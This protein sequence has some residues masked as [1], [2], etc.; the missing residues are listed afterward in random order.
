MSLS[1]IFSEREFFVFLA[2]SFTLLYLYGRTIRFHT[3]VYLS[4]VCRLKVLLAFLGTILTVAVLTKSIFAGAYTY[5]LVVGFGL[6]AFLDG[7]SGMLRTGCGEKVRRVRKEGLFLGSKTHSEKGGRGMRYI[8][9]SAV[10][11]SPG[12]YEY[13]LISIE[14]AKEW[15]SKGPFI[16][17]IGYQETADVLHKLTGYPIE[18]NRKMIKMEVGDE[19]LV[20]RLTIR[21]DDVR[22]KGEV[23]EDFIL[24]NCEIGLLKRVK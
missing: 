21:L 9:N 15:L 16:S 7:I 4:T 13:R 6:V 11:T 12:V 23:G 8:V 1:R 10:I 18:V 20:F 5:S 3:G 17:T 24:Q 14:E 19:A 2:V 22:L